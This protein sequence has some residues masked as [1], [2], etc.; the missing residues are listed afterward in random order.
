[1][2]PKVSFLITL[3]T[4]FSAATWCVPQIARNAV[5]P[6]IEVLLNER[7]DLVRGK[8]I[9]LV[10][11]HT[12]IDRRG[13]HDIDLLRALQGVKLVALLSPEHGI[14]GQAQAGETVSNTKDA[15]SGL[16]IYSLYGQVTRPTAEM[17]SGVE[18]LLYDIQDLGV[19]FYTYISTMRE[20]ME[21][22]AS[23][24]IPF[25]VLDRPDPL[26]G[27]IIEGGLLDPQFK[28]FVGAY[29]IPI[30]YGMTPG[31]LARYYCEENDLHL[32][33]EVVK[34]KGWRRGDWYDQ[35]GLP[36]VA[37]SPNIPDLESALVYP[38]TCL[39]EGTNLSEGRGTAK[40]FRIV[41]APW[42]DG[43]W[44]ARSLNERQLPG[45][46]FLAASFIPTQSKFTGQT[47]RGVEIQIMD[48]TRFRPLPGTIELLKAVRSKYSEHFQWNRDHFDRLAGS[49]QL[50]LA[51]DQGQGTQ[52]IILEWQHRLKDFEQKRQKFLL[53]PGS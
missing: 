31:E 47:C 26:G 14:R 46:K 5:I 11:N 28:S 53:Y 18:V 25:I 45:T 48:R 43:D 41:G 15:A 7:L 16:P 8:R 35:T 17:L 52:E 12:G 9:G 51:I 36:W 30:R 4:L 24:G 44:L 23:K 49:S 39:V 22:A 34:M 33:L 1:M 42:I 20:C 37:P 10:T 29:E 40:P 2:S 3:V 19:R 13:R 6:G 21:A 32:H 38:G 50:R 27:E